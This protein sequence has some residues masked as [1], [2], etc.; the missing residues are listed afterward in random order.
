MPEVPES[1]RNDDRGA[2]GCS[3]TRADSADTRPIMTV[4]ELIER[5]STVDAAE[6]V[7]LPADVANIALSAD[8]ARYALG[9]ERS[10]TAAWAR[11]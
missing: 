8:A 4:T 3:D 5:L 10:R 1:D 11:C 9:E 2:P 7:D 6:T